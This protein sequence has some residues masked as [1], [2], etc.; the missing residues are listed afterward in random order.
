MRTLL[1]INQGTSS[2]KALVFD[3]HGLL[4]AKSTVELETNPQRKYKS[5]WKGWADFLGKED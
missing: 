1:A 2:T 3:E 5:K 4:I